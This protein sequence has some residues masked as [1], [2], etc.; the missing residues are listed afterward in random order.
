MSDQ[1]ECLQGMTS[2]TCPRGSSKRL[3]IFKL[4]PVSSRPAYKIRY[5]TRW[6]EQVHYV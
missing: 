5:M 2:C 3:R 6:D 4:S 1:T